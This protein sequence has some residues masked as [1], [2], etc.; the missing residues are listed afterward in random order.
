MSETPMFDAARY[1]ECSGCH[2]A[3]TAE[4]FAHSL[5]HCLRCI[6]AAD[7]QHRCNALTHGQAATCDPA[8]QPE[9]VRRAE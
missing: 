7:A 6:A 4:D 3:R 5:T 8:F 9:L 2:G 1:G